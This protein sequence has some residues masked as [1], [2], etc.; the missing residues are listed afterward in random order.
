MG[1]D[2]SWISSD[3]LSNA[4]EEGVDYFLV[5]AL[6]NNP[7]SNVIPCSCVKCVNLCHHSIVDVRYHLFAHGFN[8]NYKV[9]SFHREKVQTKSRSPDFDY[10]Y[11][12]DYNYIKEMLHDAFAYMDQEPN[13]LQSHLE[14][15]D[16]PFYLGSKYNALSGLLKFQHLKG[17]YGWSD[18]SFDTLLDALKSVLPIDNTIP[19]S[20]YE[21]KKLLKG[22]GLQY[23]KIH[24]CENDCVLFWKEH[25]DSSHCPTCGA[26]RWKNNTK[27]VPSK[28][29]WYFPP[30]PRFQRMFSS[31]VIA[32]DLT[33][34]ARGRVNN[35]KITHPRDF[36]AWKLVDNTW[37]EFGKEDRN[38]R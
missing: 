33:W 7:I 26:S 28:V 15:C 34:H 32:H 38:I 37:K 4:Y 3:I 6:N 12:S 27:N 30:I 25:K 17:Q 23:E 21:A 13:S 8:K 9:W 31:P 20:I 11:T 24:A 36:P 5:F 18:S 14:E 2:K 35:G 29:L 1:I 19:S 22:V 16:K 10:N